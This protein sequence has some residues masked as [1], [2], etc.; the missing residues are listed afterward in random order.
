MLWNKKRLIQGS[1]YFV[2]RN[3]FGFTGNWFYSKLDG[4][5]TVDGDVMKKMAKFLYLWDLLSSEA[6]VQA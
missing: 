3:C 1:I 6:G 4:G 2:C 5:V